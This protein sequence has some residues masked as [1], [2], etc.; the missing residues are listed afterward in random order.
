MDTDYSP[1]DGLSV[2]GWPTTVITRGRVV[3]DGGRIADPGPVGQ[4]I[5]AGPIEAPYLPRS[6]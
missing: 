2:T 4:F 1:Y 5:H 6:S 3:V